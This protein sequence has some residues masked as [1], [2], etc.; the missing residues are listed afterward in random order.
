MITALLFLGTVI[1]VNIGLHAE[2]EQID[3]PHMVEIAGLVERMAAEGSAS[4][5]GTGTGIIPEQNGCRYVTAVRLCEKESDLVAVGTGDYCIREVNGHLYRFEYRSGSN[6][7]KVT[8]MVNIALVGIGVLLFGVLFYVGAKV[9]A[10]FHRMEQVPGEL[11]KGNLS[12][13][14]P[15]D[16]NKF[17]H[18]FIWGTNMLRESL[19][20]RRERELE[21]HR[22]KKMLL[23][24]LTHDI[25]TPL[26]VIK[27][28][29]QALQKNLYRDE[30]RR[31]RALTDIGGKVDEIERYV[32]QIVA[33]SREDFLDLTVREEEFYLSDLLQHV[34]DY[35]SSRL[36][37]RKTE[38]RIEEYRDCLLAGDEAR[39]EEVL[40]NIIEN[41][42]K[43]G[44]GE[45]IRIETGREDGCVLISVANTGEALGQ[46]EM[47][48]LFDSFYRGS[49]AGRQPGSGLGLYICRRLMANMNGDIFARY[50]DGEFIM[51][52]VVRMS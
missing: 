50:R 8:I 41:A 26:S 45:R 10:P 5:D 11:A 6:Q 28:N 44:D 13:P 17:L 43:Y 48:K 31:E 37:L 38:F 9:I 23:L 4:P 39:L 35:Y 15:E 12:T 24:S 52:V 18:R 16:R 29:V 25:K 27:L 36:E 7:T 22:D 46:D 3:R 51:T 40:Q 49:N 30:E 34:R 19:R 42:V 1:A 47:W 2:K 32:T 33:A 21:M 14:I 20:E